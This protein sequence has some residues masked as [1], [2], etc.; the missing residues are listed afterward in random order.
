MK[1]FSIY[2]KSMLFALISSYLHLDFTQD[3]GGIHRGLISAMQRCSN[4]CASLIAVTIKG[5]SHH[6]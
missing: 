4:T 6:D 3:T 5:N 1:A 2:S